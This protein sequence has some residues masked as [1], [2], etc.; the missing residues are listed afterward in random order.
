MLPGSGL[1]LCNG[2]ALAKPVP[3][4]RTAAADRVINLL[5]RIALNL[6]F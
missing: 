6:H 4:A 1:P 2:A 3:P 5:A